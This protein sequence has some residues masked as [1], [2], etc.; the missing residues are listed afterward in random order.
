MNGGGGVRKEEMG[1]E[2]ASGGGE[3]LDWAGRERYRGGGA[4]GAAREC[5]HRKSLA[6]GTEGVTGRGNGKQMRYGVVS[7]ISI[8]GAAGSL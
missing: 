1:G 2:G 8:R 7:P 3:H 5:F 4:W 6:G